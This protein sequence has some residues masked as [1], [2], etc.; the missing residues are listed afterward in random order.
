LVR[1]IN[2]FEDLQGNFGIKFQPFSANTISTDDYNWYN[3]YKELYFSP[4]E[5]DTIFSLVY[6]QKGIWLDIFDSYGVEIFNRN[7]EKIKGI[8]F[9][10]SVLFNR[11]VFGLLK[12]SDLSE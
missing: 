7:I 9:Q 10:S 4:E 11:E 12:E 1:L 6:K 8:K 5:W 3:V 2:S